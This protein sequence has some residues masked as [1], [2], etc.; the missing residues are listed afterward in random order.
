MKR[1]G[2]I[3]A[4]C[5]PAVQRGGMCQRFLHANAAQCSQKWQCLACASMQL[6]GE[7]IVKKTNTWKSGIFLNHYSKRTTEYVTTHKAVKNGWKF[8][9]TSIENQLFVT[10]SLTWINKMP[11]L[12]PLTINDTYTAYVFKIIIQANKTLFGCKWFWRI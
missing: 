1:E 12:V 10:L 9:I 3:G 7:S 6:P 11:L 5:K 4:L 2:T 8:K